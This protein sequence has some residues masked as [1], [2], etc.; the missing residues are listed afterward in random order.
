MCRL[1]NNVKVGVKQFGQD[2]GQK[3][4]V[5]PRSFP[6]QV[7]F[8]VGRQRDQPAPG[9]GVNSYSRA[10]ESISHCLPCPV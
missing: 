1:E 6:K 8:T 2:E 4:C 7:T 9:A 10:P 3:T 5:P